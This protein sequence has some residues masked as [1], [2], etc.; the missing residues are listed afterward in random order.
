MDWWS[1]GLVPILV[2]ILR[3]TQGAGGTYEDQKIKSTDTEKSKVRPGMNPMYDQF[4][5]QCTTNFLSNV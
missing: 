1:R 3:Q 5:A 4:W 2:P